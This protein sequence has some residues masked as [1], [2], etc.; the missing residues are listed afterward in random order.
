MNR[1]RAAR[2][3]RKGALV[4]PLVGYPS[5]VQTPHY[6]TTLRYFE[7]VT[8][9]E[10]TVGVG[11]DYVWS[12]NSV[13]DPNTTGA[14]V[15]PIGYT[16]MA[17]FYG[18]YKVMA[19]T[20]KVVFVNDTSGSTLCGV[21][22]TPQSTITSDRGAWPIQPNAQWDLLADQHAGGCKLVV[23]R[24]YDLARVAGVE[25]SEYINDQ[26]FGSIIGANPSRPLYL[27]TWMRGISVAAQVQ[28]AVELDY[29]V[30][31]SQPISLQR[32]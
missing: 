30:E 17:A 26:D 8:L 24:K 3:T 10:A 2:N 14:G 1:R 5:T 27:H 6:K 11:N 12:L 19:V 13:Y 25:R 15:N 20:I 23:S 16:N 31:F 29:H 28:I 22:A 21:V 9:P 18:R 4:S 7:S 32:M